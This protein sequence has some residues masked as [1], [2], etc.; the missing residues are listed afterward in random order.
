VFQSQAWDKPSQLYYAAIPTGSLPA[1][2]PIPLATVDAKYLSVKIPV[3][4]ADSERAKASWLCH[5]SQYTPEQIEAMHQ[6]IRA[7]LKGTMYFQPLIAVPNERAS[8][9]QD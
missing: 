7:S 9:F 3:S 8:L 1:S 2:S 4:D 5:K 6:M